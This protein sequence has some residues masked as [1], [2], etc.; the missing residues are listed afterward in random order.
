MADVSFDDVNEMNESMTKV[1]EELVSLSQ[2]S[3]PN[4]TNEKLNI[5]NRKR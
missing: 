2:V 4:N 1:S 3:K 5:T